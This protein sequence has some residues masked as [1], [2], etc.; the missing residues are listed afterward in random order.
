MVCEDSSVPEEREHSIDEYFRCAP[1]A[2]GWAF[3]LGLVQWEGH[4]PHIE[5]KDFRK[6]QKEPTERRKLQA[7]AAAVKRW[8]RTCT[9]CGELNNPGHMHDRRLCQGCATG[10]LGIVY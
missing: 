1:A 8:I 6:W 5:W 9:H 3:Q 10:V 7:K 4:Q 2:D